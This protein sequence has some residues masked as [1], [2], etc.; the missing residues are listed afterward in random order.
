MKNLQIQTS[1]Y[2]VGKINNDT[3]NLLLNGLIIIVVVIII[4]IITTTIITTT[5]IIIICKCSP[6]MFP[7]VSLCL[8]SLLISRKASYLI[9]CSIQIKNFI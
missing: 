5:I 8:S 6:I 4:I 3:M 2:V 9:S 7:F 1:G